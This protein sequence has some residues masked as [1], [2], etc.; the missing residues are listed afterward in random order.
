VAL[1][2]LAYG[3]ALRR[4]KSRNP[5]RWLSIAC[6][7]ALSAILLHSFVDFNLYV[8]ANGFLAVWV[9]AMARES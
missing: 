5:G 3:S 9:A 4:T 6:V 2:L 1:T 8:P 7:G